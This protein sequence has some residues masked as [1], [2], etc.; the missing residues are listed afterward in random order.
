M[1]VIIVMNISIIIPLYKP[2]KEL[3]SKIKRTIKRQNY[4]GKL[5]IIEID[6]SLGLAASLNLGI[7]KAKYPVIVS[8]HQDC[9]PISDNWLKKLVEPLKNENVVAVASDVYDVEN[10]MTYTP[11]LDEKGCAYKKKCLMEVGLFDD[12]TFLNSGED[13]DMYM[14]LKDLGRIEYPRCKVAHYH[15]GFLIK[16]SRYKKLQNAN[17]YGCLFRIYGF[18]LK[19]WWKPFLLANP[20]NILYSYWFW[21]GFITKRQRFGKW[22]NKN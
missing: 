5:E 3:L 17:T 7:R 14:K 10:K 16:K 20:F 6:E 12:K 8:L 1:V 15:K 11:F 19:N 9:V 18:R 22:Q 21:R 4:L 13:M 2:N